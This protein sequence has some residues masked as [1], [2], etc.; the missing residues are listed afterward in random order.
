MRL[1]SPILILQ[2]RPAMHAYGMPTG[3]TFKGSRTLCKADAFGYQTPIR[4]RTHH[5]LPCTLP[6]TRVCIRNHPPDF[7]PTVTLSQVATTEN[8]SR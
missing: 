4:R 3:P 1:P 7:L 8:I 2:I 5:S 6:P